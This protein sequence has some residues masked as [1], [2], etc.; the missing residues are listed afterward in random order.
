LATPETDTGS[1]E[2]VSIFLV[3]GELAYL[4]AQALARDD[5]DFIADP[6]VGLEVEGQAGVVSL[7]NHLQGISFLSTAGMA[8]RLALA[9]FFTVLVRTRLDDI[10]LWVI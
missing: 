10:S 8:E 4:V 7:D 3:A 1:P 2:K 6:L 9:D 5:S